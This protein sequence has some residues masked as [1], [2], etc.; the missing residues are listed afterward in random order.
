MN[1][2]DFTVNQLKRAA[3]IKEQLEA[4]NKELHAI[5]GAPVN[6]RAA[7]KKNHERHRK[8]QGG[9]TFAEPIRQRNQLQPP[10]G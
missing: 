10:Q 1:L 8:K 4:L 6:T 7:R 5:L 3:A 2:F 9:R